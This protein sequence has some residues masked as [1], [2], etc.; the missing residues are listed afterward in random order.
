MVGVML[1]GSRKT[2][3]CTDQLHMVTI[4]VKWYLWVLLVSIIG[5]RT[6]KLKC[7]WWV[8]MMESGAIDGLQRDVVGKPRACSITMMMVMIYEVCGPSVCHQIQDEEVMLMLS[9]SMDGSHCLMHDAVSFVHVCLA[10]DFQT[11]VWPSIWRSVYSATSS[12]LNAA[13]QS[14]KEM[15]DRHAQN[16]IR[17][18]NKLL[19]WQGGEMWGGG[20]FWGSQVSWYVYVCTLRSR[21]TNKNQ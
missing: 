10:W 19:D 21:Y 15:E 3:E 5:V 9:M 1:M 18:P 12:L 4:D 6:Q 13:Q 14:P 17:L 11:A 20:S 8:S 2:K 7:Q 16:F